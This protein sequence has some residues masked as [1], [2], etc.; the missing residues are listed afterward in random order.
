MGSL[1]Q[2]PVAVAQGFDEITCFGERDALFQRDVD[3]PAAIGGVVLNPA[4]A[5]GVQPG[6]DP[7]DVSFDPVSAG[8]GGVEVQEDGGACAIGSENADGGRK[9]RQGLGQGP[10]ML[11][12]VGLAGVT[13]EADAGLP[14]K[15]G[16]ECGPGQGRLG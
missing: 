7:S 2:A 16:S 15:Q 14:G 11:L 8:D 1:V 12:R 6:L 13:G 9:G 3:V 5:E 10:F 4:G